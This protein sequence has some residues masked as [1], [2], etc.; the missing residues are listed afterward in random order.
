VSLTPDRVHAVRTGPYTDAYSSR[1]YLMSRSAIRLARI[2]DTHPRHQTLPDR[3]PRLPGRRG[4]LAVL[5]L[6]PAPT[7]DVGRLIAAM[8]LPAR[9]TSTVG[10][11][12][13]GG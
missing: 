4:P 7:L 6:E 13:D 9:E 5:K 8:R 12:H 3:R 11:A 1:L 2:G 10:A